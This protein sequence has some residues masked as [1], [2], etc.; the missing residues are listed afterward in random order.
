MRRIQSYYLLMIAVMLLPNVVKAQADDTL[1]IMSYNL[2]NYR[3]SGIPGC[4]N[5]NNN[6]TTKEAGLKAIVD[7]SLPDILVCN[8]ISSTDPVASF[9]LL[10]NSMN[11][12]GR[13]YYDFTTMN[14]G[15]RQMNNSSAT[16]NMIFFDSSK[17]VLHNI[18]YIEFDPFNRA[19]VRVIDLFSLY[20]KDPNLAIHGDTTFIHVFVAHLKAGNT[21]SDRD[22]RGW[23]TNAVMA[24]LDSNNLDG[25]YF[26]GG[27]LNLYRSS[28]T[29]YQ[30]M[31]NYSNASHRFYDPINVPGTWTNNGSY[32]IVHTQST[33]S[34]SGCGATGG[35]DDRFDFILASDEVM[36]GTDSVKY[37]AN[38]YLALGQDG[39]HFNSAVNGSPTN[40]SVP[41]AVLQ[42]LAD[43]SDHL[44]VLM[45]V[46]IHLPLTNSLV[47][48]RP[49]IDI[50]FNNPVTDI[51]HL[52]VKSEHQLKR[53][54]ILDMAGRVVREKGLNNKRSIDLGLEDLRSG[55]YFLKLEGANSEYPVQKLIKN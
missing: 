7:Y 54:Q 42:G 33:R 11:Q 28:E 14:V 4:S 44:P 2:L 3:N 26:L 43:V 20:Y 32:A 27:D 37:I 48:K 6:P 16:G 22:E 24:Y 29:A 41:A 46:E 39:Q 17:L 35:M 1:R 34:T 55:V 31:L 40:T 30:N 5:A 12:S 50:T 52:K 21:T 10:Q 13:T 47:A 36:N 38:S 25:N 23:A 18:D 49:N 51:L 9:R 15:Q 45:D 53:I 19:L 8:E